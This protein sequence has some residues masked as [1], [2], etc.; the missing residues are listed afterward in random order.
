MDILKFAFDRFFSL[1]KRQVRST[2]VDTMYDVVRMMKESSV[3]GKNI[4]MPTVGKRYFE[5]VLT[6]WTV[7]PYDS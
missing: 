5:L 4:L 3:A 2:T 6:A 7:L 1:F